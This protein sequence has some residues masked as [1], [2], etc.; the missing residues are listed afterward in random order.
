MWSC[1]G[2]WGWRS[3]LCS[4]GDSGD[5]FSGLFLHCITNIFLQNNKNF[6]NITN[7]YHFEGVQCNVWAWHERRQWDK[8]A[9]QR[10]GHVSLKRNAVLHLHWRGYPFTCAF[11]FTFSIFIYNFTLYKI[12]KAPNLVTMPMELLIAAN[13]YNL[14]RLQV[15]FKSPQIV[16]RI[17][18]M[19]FSDLFLMLW[20]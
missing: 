12:L 16:C 9:H 18:K 20:I 15:S 6:F 10:N 13:R 19:D 14:H 2:N 8:S 1:T 11:I 3:C 7:L 5:S 17:S 4:S